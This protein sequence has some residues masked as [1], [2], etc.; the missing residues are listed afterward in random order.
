VV[1]ALPMSPSWGCEHRM[2]SRRKV[3]GH[4]DLMKLR[5]RFALIIVFG[6][7][8]VLGVGF[9][10]VQNDQEQALTD[11]AHRRASA[12]L[13]V[14]TAS[15][16]MVKESLRPAI[17][18]ELGRF[19][20]EAMSSTFVTRATF[21]RLSA[22]LADYVYRQPTL[23]PLNPTNKADAFEAALIERFR[24][25]PDLDVINGTREVEG[26]RLY[27]VARPEVVEERCLDCHGNPENAPPGLVER[28][29]TESGFGW[30]PGEIAGLTLVTVPIDDLLG[31]QATL[32]AH[33]LLVFLVATVGLFLLMLFSFDRIVNRRIEKASEVMAAVEAHPDLCVRVPEIG[34]DELT[35]M[36]RA[37]NRMADS[38]RDSTINLETRVRDRTRELE[39]ARDEARRAERAKDEFLA[40]MSHELRTPLT[41]ILGYAEELEIRRDELSASCAE[42]VRVISDNGKHLMHLIN[43]I[44][45]LSKILAGRMEIESEDWSPFEIIEDVQSLLEVKARQKRV[46][47][48]VVVEGMLPEQMKG[49][50]ARVKQ[51]LINLV[52]NALKFTEEGRV[53]LSARFER[54]GPSGRLLFDVADT[55]I[56][57]SEEQAARLFERFRQADMST[58][59][60][61]G[62]TGLGLDISRR[63]AEL[64]G[65]RL[66]LVHSEVG[67]GSTFRLELPME[68]LEDLRLIRQ[69]PK[70]SE[71]DTGLAHTD[72]GLACRVL[73][74]EDN[75]VNQRIVLRILERFGADVDVVGDGSQA[76]DAALEA[77][78]DGAPFSVVLMDMHM[79][80]MDGVAAIKELRARGYERPIVVLT[81]AILPHEQ[82]RCREAGC[83]A[84]A[85]KP[86]DRHA[87]FEILFE[88]TTIPDA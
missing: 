60:R 54:D 45:D 61:F 66:S 84:F 3:R 59:R 62:G 34:S 58:T 37:F 50:A 22:E 33:V 46:E 40:N 38:V 11:V 35:D 75:P 32:G 76:V 42:S 73:V 81:A 27:Y 87:L 6:I 23:N 15:R 18:D 86:V 79:P 78:R 85:A 48:E 44:L 13:A 17:S 65:G 28:Y 53:T 82:E 43:D 56:G 52:G 7:L 25:D 74:A 29:G 31:H 36:A 16:R 71:R 88:L 30:K 68:D 80:V 67:K 72:G 4:L 64:M 55:G 9:W 41:A 19:T 70:R 12:V 51:I 69:A 2:C 24:R 49:D 1:G 14:A 8:G 20:P 47:L 5:T 21:E 10:V 63:L 77:E 26:R 83:D 57:M 39:E